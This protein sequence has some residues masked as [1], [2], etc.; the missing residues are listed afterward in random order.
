[1]EA[2]DRPANDRLFVSRT[3]TIIAVFYGVLVVVSVALAVGVWWSTRRRGRTDTELL[4]RRETGW[5][6]LAGALLV[7]LLF[8]TI[9][10]TPFGRSVEGPRQLVRVTGL[11]FAWVIEPQAVRANVP[12][13][14]RLESADVSHSFAVYDEDFALLF[15]AQVVPGRTQKVVYTFKEPGTYRVLCLEFCGF[16][17]DVMQSTL[18]V[19]A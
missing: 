12:V 18:E 7:A 9:F 14:F 16:G 10:F 19:K 1:M 4:A 15:Q 8:A 17:H 6:A 11:Q 5:F 3:A 13:E 2:A